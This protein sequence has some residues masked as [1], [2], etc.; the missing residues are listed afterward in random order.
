MSSASYKRETTHAAM[1]NADELQL[2]C[3][4]YN[5]GLLSYDGMCRALF[6]QRVTRR[7][8]FSCKFCHMMFG[9]FPQLSNLFD[10]RAKT[11]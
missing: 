10:E 8:G 1:P 2:V 5:A 9:R 4:H 7:R 11:A 3:Y 6:E